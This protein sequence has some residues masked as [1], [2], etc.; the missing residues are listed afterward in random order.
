[1]R[2][3]EKAKEYLAKEDSKLLP[4]YSKGLVHTYSIVS[5]NDPKQNSGDKVIPRANQS[6]IPAKMLSYAPGNHPKEREV[7]KPEEHIKRGEKGDMG[8]DGS[9]ENGSELSDNASMW[10]CLS[11]NQRARIRSKMKD[12]QSEE[13]E[14][15]Q[16]DREANENSC[17]ANGAEEEGALDMCWGKR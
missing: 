15:A 17:T 16:M 9:L 6:F 2:I 13:H 14:D 3:H 8:D 1:M 5:I 10:T 7:L 11:Y 4:Q 12:I